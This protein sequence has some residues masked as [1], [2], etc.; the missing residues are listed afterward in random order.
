MSELSAPSPTGGAMA[1]ARAAAATPARGLS[2]LV[3][4]R[5]L[6][7]AALILLLSSKSAAELATPDGKVKLKAQVKQIINE[8]MDS[9]EEELVQSVLFTSFIIQ[10][11]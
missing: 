3:S 4:R 2:G 10:K 5:G 7:M 11:Q 9:G 1:G 8:S 6:G